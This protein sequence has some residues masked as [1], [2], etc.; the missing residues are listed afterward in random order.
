[1]SDS[2][3]ELTVTAEH[4]NV[5][6]ESMVAETAIEVSAAIMDP[7][8][9]VTAAAAAALKRALRQWCQRTDDVRVLRSVLRSV[10]DD[11]KP[12]QLGA[13]LRRWTK[14]IHLRRDAAMQRF[15][16]SAWIMRGLL[17]R[18]KQEAKAKAAR[19]RA[20]LAVRCGVVQARPAN[21]NV[22]MRFVSAVAARAWNCFVSK[23]CGAESR[24]AMFAGRNCL[25]AVTSATRNCLRAITSATRNCL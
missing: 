2:A 14:Y 16:E 24:G 18:W 11:A 20:T 12:L 21:A 1:M 19:A 6:D 4:G 15:R 8:L 17:A 13:V 23:V 3:D 10:D 7:T 25:R 5:T 9:Q 22:P